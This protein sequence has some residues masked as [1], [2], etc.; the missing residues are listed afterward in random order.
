[1]ALWQAPDADARDGWS[2]PDKS[3]SLPAGLAAAGLD[4][5]VRGMTAALGAPLRPRDGRPRPSPLAKQPAVTWGV[6]PRTP[7]S[8]DQPLQ[9]DGDRA[10]KRYRRDRGSR[11][12]P[13]QCSCIWTS[14][15][16]LRAGT[17]IGGHSGVTWTERLAIR[18][19]KLLLANVLCLLLLVTSVCWLKYEGWLT[20]DP[21]PLCWRLLQDPQEWQ[22][23]GTEGG[24]FTLEM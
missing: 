17:G 23:Q 14:A 6:A 18:L 13:Q 10:T 12:S 8:R 21:G 7:F 3:S 15:R 4:H 19:A 9:K 20:V 16:Y 1:M 11:A 2:K 22:V 24:A 5:V